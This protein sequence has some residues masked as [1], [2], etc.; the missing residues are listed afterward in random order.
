MCPSSTEVSGGTAGL[1]YLR[2]TLKT[3]HRIS[4]IERATVW[5][6]SWGPVADRPR[7]FQ[8][9]RGPLN[10]LG[11]G[12]WILNL[13]RSTGSSWLANIVSDHWK[14][15][16][17]SKLQ[18]K[19]KGEE[20]SI[21]ALVFTWD[22]HAGRLAALTSD[23]IDLVMSGEEIGCDELRVAVASL[24]QSAVFLQ[25]SKGVGTACAVLCMV[26]VSGNDIQLVV[27]E[28]RLQMDGI[29]VDLDGW[30]CGRIVV[31]SRRRSARL[32]STLVG[33]LLLA[34]LARSWIVVAYVG[35][36]NGRHFV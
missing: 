22:V 25:G 23:G 18:A 4:L 10:N 17:L 36:L 11:T 29:L 7:A 9:L 26:F 32:L 5:G 3:V 16:L 13:S 35:V 27:P 34:W 12:I 21:G 20:Q 28:L 14:G 33:C 24:A 15:F 8:S 6:A 30:H 31:N 2:V 19:L 1:V